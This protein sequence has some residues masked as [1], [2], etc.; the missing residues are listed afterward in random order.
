MHA[1]SPAGSPTR[2]SRR[3]YIVTIGVLLLACVVLASWILLHPRGGP[4][5]FAENEPRV[6]LVV[7]VMTDQAARSQGEPAMEPAAVVTAVGEANGRRLDGLGV[8]KWNVRR[9]DPPDRLLVQLA[10]AAKPDLERIKPAILQSGM[11]ALHLVEQGPAS[12]REALLQATGGVLPDSM[13]IATGIVME[14]RGAATTVYYLLR[15]SPAVTSKDIAKARPIMDEAG[16]PAVSFTMTDAGAVRLKR[17]T[18]A[19]IGRNL[20]IVINGAVMSAP[21][22]DDAIGAEGRIHG[23]FTREEAADLALVL[24]S[25]AL[26][27]PVVAV[28]ERTVGV[29]AKR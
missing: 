24:R 14:E 23:G 15:K 22:I 1:D 3:A 6:E 7:Q 20:A 12:S 29:P 4:A 28:E 16:Q 13:D 17:A 5:A 21:R 10:I 19:N 18:A 25:G 26:A 8:A 11:L 2:F 9:H 27:A